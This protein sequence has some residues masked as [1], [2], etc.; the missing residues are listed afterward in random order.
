VAI[1]EVEE[2]EYNLRFKGRYFDGKTRLHCNRFRSYSPDTGQF[3]NQVPIGLLGGI[4]NCQ[5]APN[6]A[7]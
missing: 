4:N 5:Y 6:T 3:I 2:V 7:E 1:K